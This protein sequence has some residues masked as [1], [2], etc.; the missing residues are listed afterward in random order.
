MPWSVFDDLW[1]V[2]PERR[3]LGWSDVGRWHVRKPY[4]SVNVYGNDEALIVTSEVPG[5]KADE[6][7]I[8]V[9]GRSLTIKGAREAEDA[10][11]DNEPHRERRTGD[12]LR[13]VTL[14]YEVETDRIEADYN[15]GV[16]KIK[17]PKAER[18]KPRKINVTAA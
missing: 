4:P 13:S 16:L 11:G 6:L 12:F 3:G 2:N 10:G 1:N 15:R 8:S 14:P 9:Q 18:L 17:L 5:I 7:D